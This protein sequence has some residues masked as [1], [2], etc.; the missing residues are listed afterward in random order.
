MLRFAPIDLEL[1]SRAAVAIRADSFEVSFGSSDEFFEEYGM[2]GEGYLNHLRSRMADQPGSCVHA[3]KG[4]E[5]VG[6]IELRD[7][8]E[9]PQEGYVNLY[10]LM[11]EFRGD[12]LGRELDDHAM[13]WFCESGMTSHGTFPVSGLVW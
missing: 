8:R 4:D 12:G 1:R 5:L 7:G 3:W 10:Y 13:R 9:T 2:T 11:P 6:Q